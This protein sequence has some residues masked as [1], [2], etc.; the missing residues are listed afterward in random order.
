MADAFFL[1]AADVAV[2]NKL[3]AAEVNRIVNTPS[4]PP[5]ERSYDEGEDHQAPETYL[6]IPHVA[7]PGRVGLVPGKGT[8]DIY[9]IVPTASPLMRDMKFDETEVYNYR[10]MP[11]PSSEYFPVTRTKGGR[12]IPL[13][14]SN[15]DF[16]RFAIVSADVG[17]SPRSAT[18][19]IL[20]RTCG[21]STVPE[22]DPAPDAR[23]GTGTGEVITVVYDMAGCFLNEPAADLV[24]RVGFAKYMIDEEREGESTATGTG[25]G[26][27]A[28]TD[29]DL[30]AW[31]IVNLC[32]ATC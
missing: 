28:A 4:R 27:G 5:Q 31:S 23:T 25:T 14:A 18:V 12:W 19:N 32:C 13:V 16:I 6:A 10:R 26:T 24:G 2:I 22:E 9:E 8:C 15:C 11:I 30:C 21:C 20:S 29:Q 3:V 1:T 7:I 17:S